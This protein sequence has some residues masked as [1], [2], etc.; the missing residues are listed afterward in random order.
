MAH[1]QAQHTSPCDDGNYCQYMLFQVEALVSEMVGYRTREQA[2][3]DRAA[4]AEASV[5]EALLSKDALREEI[6]VERGEYGKRMVR[7]LWLH[8][9]CL[10]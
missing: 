5:M 9:T 3:L 2:L 4:Q 7:Q 6:E 10:S 8:E 1:A